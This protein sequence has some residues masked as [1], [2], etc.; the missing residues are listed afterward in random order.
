MDAKRRSVQILGI[1]TLILGSLYGLS[2]LAAFFGAPLSDIWLLLTRVL[3]LALGAYLIWAGIRMIRRAK[4]P[5][6]L[7]T[8]RVKGGRALLGS[9]LTFNAIKTHLH[10]PP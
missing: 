5:P 1:L 7:Q 9:L 8:G 2:V 6:S 4:G 3:N 10:P